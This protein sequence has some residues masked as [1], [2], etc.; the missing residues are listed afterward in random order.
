M[1]K[2]TK[3]LLA[4]I[5]LATITA[6][7]AQAADLRPEPAQVQIAETVPVAIPV[8]SRNVTAIRRM[9]TPASAAPTAGGPQK[10]PPPAAKALMALGL[11]LIVTPDMFGDAFS[12]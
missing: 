1:M 8:E 6:Q 11:A 4:A 7:P 2:Y 10:A 12:N 5:L 9:D 3:A